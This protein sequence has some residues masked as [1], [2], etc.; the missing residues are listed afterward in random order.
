MAG[1]DELDRSSG[2]SLVDGA[3]LD[4]STLRV[5]ASAEL[6]SESILEPEVRQAFHLAVGELSRHGVEVI[7]DAPRLRDS[8]ETW[9]T[10]AAAESF[11]SEGRFLPS[12]PSLFSDQ[13]REFLAFGQKVSLQRFLAAQAA[14]DDVM[15]AFRGIFDRYQASIFITPT[16]GTVPPPL[17]S[18]IDMAFDDS[19]RFVLDASL[20]G[21]PACSIPIADG[22]SSLPIGMHIVGRRGADEHVL[23][24]AKLF[25]DMLNGSKDRVF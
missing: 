1:H 16:M 22:V 21:S 10:I 7:W 19:D 11:Y 15:Q 25:T 17:D 20:T 9:L 3:R 14:R 23:A 8:T 24:V 5:I 2:L 12:A 4:P 6:R 18:S 13:A